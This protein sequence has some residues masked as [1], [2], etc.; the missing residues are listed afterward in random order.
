MVSGHNQ[1]D[2]DF[3]SVLRFVVSQW[4]GICAGALA[5][6]VLG[7]A[8]AVLIE[9]SYRA[10]ALLAPVTESE[11]SGGLGSAVSQLGGLAA[12]AGVN[13]GGEESV[14]E[15]IA[16]LRSREFG[17]EFIRDNDLVRVLFQDDW[18]AAAGVW[19]RDEPPTLWETWERF[20]EDVRR[21]EVDRATGLVQLAVEW[22][23]P[24]LA[25]R[26]T[27][28][29][30]AMANQRIRANAIDE[31][32][33]SLE[34]LNEELEKA[35][36]LELREAIYRLVESQVNRIMFANVRREYA[37]RVL[38]EAVAPDPDDFVRPNRPLLILGGAVLGGGLAFGILGLAAL[39]PRGG[40]SGRAVS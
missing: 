7:V 1:A 35:S 36:V 33:R 12:L 13:V 40:D 22:T 2:L 6:L 16:I 15:Y 11:M 3:G 20:D 26:W 14:N 19:D 21:V 25:A 18:D 39:W 27:N 32:E 37:F 24:A 4:R 30:V 5:G 9:P 8:G 17:M 28:D 31:A 10:T 29:I 38:D 34:Y 23:D